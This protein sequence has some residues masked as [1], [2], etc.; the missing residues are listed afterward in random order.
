MSSPHFI[1]Q[2]DL[3][4]LKRV[5]GYSKTDAAW[6]DWTGWAIYWGDFRRRTQLCL[7]LTCGSNGRNI[8]SIW[9]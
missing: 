4:S 6:F 1:Y 9:K 2:F 3:A 8:Y 5:E 7:Y